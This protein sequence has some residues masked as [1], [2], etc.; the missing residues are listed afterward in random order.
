MW[1]VASDGEDSNTCH[2]KVAGTFSGTIDWG[3]G[4]ATVVKFE[5]RKQIT[6]LHESAG[7]YTIII[8]MVTRSKDGR[9]KNGGDKLK[10]TDVSNWGT[11]FVFDRTRMFQGCANMDVSAT[12]IPTISTTSFHSQFYNS[13]ITTPDW[14]AW[15]MTGV[16]E[17]LNSVL[18][19]S[20]FQWKHCVIG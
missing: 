6:H 5:L 15:D 13:G 7:T 16:T 12:D 20:S 14:S 1:N 8:S 4:G 9:L 10:I 3:D 11:G 18:M 17:L 19:L 2:T